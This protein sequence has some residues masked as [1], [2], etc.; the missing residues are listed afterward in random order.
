MGLFKLGKNG[1]KGSAEVGNVDDWLKAL[2]ADV[3]AVETA[4][5]SGTTMGL[6]PVPGL[7]APHPEPA[8]VAGLDVSTPPPAP[9]EVEDPAWATPAPIADP[10]KGGW[11]LPS[12]ASDLD[13]PAEPSEIPVPVSPQDPLP[14]A[15]A[16]T[17]LATEPLPA[18]TE[19]L[20]AQAKN[21]SLAPPVEMAPSL[22]SA[23][24]AE[25]PTT[26]EQPPSDLIITPDD[27]E[28]ADFGVFLDAP[29][30][31][32]PHPFE[33]VGI[34]GEARGRIIET[35]GSAILP[36]GDNV[37]TLL[38]ILGLDRDVTWDEVKQS[39][40]ALIADHQAAGESD[41]ERADLA[42]SIRREINSAY[43]ALRLLQVP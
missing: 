4:H 41:L 24:L 30:D 36:Q 32:V 42:R 1:Q 26:I 37:A 43:I 34:A 14:P 35:N 2:D 6:Q 19:P 27:D 38:A 21:L 25:D 28:L 29:E 33:Q 22:E 9:P 31:D 5:G 15:W 3:D 7:D 20:P 13:A 12:L 18:P 11:H 17:P 40:A 10:S 23:P 8:P 16:Q 39:H